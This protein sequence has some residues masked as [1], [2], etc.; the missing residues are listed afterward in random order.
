MTKPTV[1]CSLRLACQFI[2]YIF[3][4]NLTGNKSKSSTITTF[5]PRFSQ[6][7]TL[8]HG[9]T[10][11]AYAASIAVESVMELATVIGDHCS[12]KIEQFCCMTK[13]KCVYLIGAN[14]SEPHTSVT[15]L[16]TCVCMSACLLACG[17][18]PKI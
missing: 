17:H 4:R 6:R 3:S 15:V 16:R 14:L 12:S 13:R 11:A 9:T 10:S 2:N 8:R 5:F 18:I 1:S 7:W